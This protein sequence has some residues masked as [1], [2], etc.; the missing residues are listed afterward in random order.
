MRMAIAFALFAGATL[1][2][3]GAASAVPL[4]LGDHAAVSRNLSNAA[5]EPVA[6]RPH[7]YS[8]RYAAKYPRRYSWLSLLAALSVSLLAVLLPVWRPAVLSGD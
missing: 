6:R 5:L 3:P 1:L 7:K 4:A 8:K 2:A